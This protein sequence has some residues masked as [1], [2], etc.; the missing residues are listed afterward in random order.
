MYRSLYQNTSIVDFDF[1]ES[2]SESERERIAI[3]TGQNKLRRVRE[4]RE[5]FLA[6]FHKRLGKESSLLQFRSGTLF[7]KHLLTTLWQFIDHQ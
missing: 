5:A 1:S 4:K 2:R 3:R 6:G 7:E